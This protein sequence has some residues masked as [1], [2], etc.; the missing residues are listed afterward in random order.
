[1]WIQFIHEYFIN[2]KKKKRQPMLYE[3]PSTRLTGGRFNIKQ[4]R[5]IKTA[6]D[7]F[8]PTESGRY[9]VFIVIVYCL[10]L[11]IF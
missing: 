5:Y 8:T 7:H 1:M 11:F 2:F 3:N 9:S 10:F 6:V 4:N